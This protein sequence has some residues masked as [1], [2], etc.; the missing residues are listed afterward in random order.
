MIYAI[1]ILAAGYVPLL[2]LMR[3]DRGEIS[4]LK[5]INKLQESANAKLTRNAR[6]AAKPMDDDDADAGARRRAG[7]LH[8]D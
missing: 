6:I 3:R 2:W 8:K 1:L 4:R 5:T 7:K